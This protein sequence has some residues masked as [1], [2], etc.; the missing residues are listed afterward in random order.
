MPAKYTPSSPL[1][2]LGST[3]QCLE[4]GTCATIEGSATPPYLLLDDVWKDH[5]LTSFINPDWS[6]SE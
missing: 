3:S 6:T 4:R 2:L 5:I 1:E